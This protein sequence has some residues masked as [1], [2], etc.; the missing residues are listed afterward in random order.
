MKH[1]SFEQI[2]RE[3]TPPWDHGAADFN[4][5]ETIQRHAIKPCKALDL[6]C[7][8]GNN[9]IWLAQHDFGVVGFDLSATA[10]QR[11][12]E[13][14]AEAGV[15]CRL[16][17]G[18][19]LKDE[20]EG[21]PFG[22]VFDRGCLHCIDDPTDRARFAGKV[23]A[24]LE[25]GGMWLS[26][27]GNAD[28][29]KREVGP[30]RLSALETIHATELHFELLSLTSGIFGDKQEDPPRAWICLMRKRG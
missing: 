26:L 13:R 10:I 5:A 4:L 7:G 28:E 20:V 12:G 11:A 17:V 15:E 1:N 22:F 14:L 9:V 27:I 19:F 23:A 29:P 3:G 16:Q 21:A 2:Y 30:P 6:G 25:A 18:D 24:L 8:M